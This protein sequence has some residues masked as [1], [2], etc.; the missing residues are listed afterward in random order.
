MHQALQAYQKNLA[1][2]SISLS[3][4]LP[5]SLEHYI[6]LSLQK[7]LSQASREYKEFNDFLLR[8]LMNIEEQRGK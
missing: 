2:V 3:E 8:R 4:D 1:P 6:P 7:P 5:K